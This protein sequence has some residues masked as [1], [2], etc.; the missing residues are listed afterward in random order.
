MTD[1]NYYYSG[2]TLSFLLYQLSL[3]SSGLIQSKLHNELTAAFPPSATRL[4]PFFSKSQGG[5]MEVPSNYSEFLQTISALPY[6]DAVIK[7]TLR[8][9]PAI[10]GTLP[11]V[12]PQGAGRGKIIDGLCIPP[13]TV[14]GSFAY[15]I[16]R[17]TLVFGNEI[18]DPQRWIITGPPEVKER[19]GSADGTTVVGMHENS[20]VGVSDETI[21][22][23]SMEQR[24]WAFGSGGRGCVG[25]QYVGLADHFA[26]KMHEY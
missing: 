1:D 10:P 2:D 3:P 15:G 8:V 14:V 26:P 5:N 6:L 20:V 21:R 24:L 18:F 11:R 9:Y 17:D 23:K 25:K 4:P 12:V 13:G 7:E 19:Q 22:I 16:H